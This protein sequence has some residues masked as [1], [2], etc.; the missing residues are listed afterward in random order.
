VTAPPLR[1]DA[2]VEALR[3]AIHHREQVEPFLD[4]VLF[5]HPTVRAAYVELLGSDGVGQAVDTAGP[6]ASALLARLAVE[7]PSAGSTDVLSRLA[8]EVGRRVLGDLER[9]ARSAADPLAYSESIRWLKVTLEQ[10][11]G[12]RSEVE[13]LTQLLVWLADRRRPTGQG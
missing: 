13:I 4:P 6:E 3:L 11:R 12:P 9:D 2:E 7:T 10:L 5:E 8:T 1:D